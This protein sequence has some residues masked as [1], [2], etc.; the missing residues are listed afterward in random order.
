MLNPNSNPNNEVVKA[1]LR[2]FL[3]KR[4]RSEV[5]YSKIMFNSGFND[6]IEVPFQMQIFNLLLGVLQLSFTGRALDFHP[7]VQP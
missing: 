5:L 6:F 7:R 1:I 2:V 4:S 3:K